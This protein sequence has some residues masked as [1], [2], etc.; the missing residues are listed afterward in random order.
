MDPIT[1]RASALNQTALDWDGNLRRIE[2]AI[3]RAQNDGVDVL[4]LPELCLSGYGC[5]DAFL[6]P[7]TRLLALELLSTIAPQTKDITVTL[8]LPLEIDSTLYN[9]VAVVAEGR[10]HGFALKRALAGDGVYYEP[11]WFRPWRGVTKPRFEFGG[12]QLPVGDLVFERD[13]VLFGIEICEDAWVNPRRAVDIAATGAN[14]ILNPSASHFALQKNIQRMSLIREG[15]DLVDGVYVYSNLLGNDAGRLI[16]DGDTVIAGATVYHGPRFSYHSE[17]SVTAAIELRA[18]NYRPESGYELVSLPTSAVTSVSGAVPQVFTSCNERLSDFEEVYQ[19]VT[20]GLFDYMRKSRSSGFVVSL[21]GGVDS[22]VTAYLSAHAI[23]CAQQE[24]SEAEWNDA[25]GYLA[26]NVPF[27][28][29]RAVEKLLTCVYQGT[30]QSSLQ[31]REAARAIA[32]GLG[33]AFLE[34]EIDPL[35][36]QYKHLITDAGGSA[37]LPTALEWNRHDLALQNIQART[38]GPGVWLVANLKNALLLATSNRSEAAVGYTTMDGDTCGGL[39]PIAGLSKPF[40]REFLQWIVD[41]GPAGVGPFAAAAKV[42]AMEPTAELR[43]A[44]RSQTDETDLMPYDV[45]D[46]I[47]H[48]FLLERLM[49]EQMVETL[50][51]EFSQYAAD[52]I[53]LW[54][55]RFFQLWTR[56]QWKRE[57]YAPSF[58]LDRVSL[59]PKAWCRFPILS[60]G[61]DRELRRGKK[62]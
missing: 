59:D 3:A 22:A 17:A 52:D 48:L 40:L 28:D 50:E 9:A 49:P 18:A 14:A 46:R 36:E 24:L 10:V 7:G 20:L 55:K 1:F 16:F 32:H 44:E 37:G 54:M 47:E 62:L 51:R 53:A 61:F 12:E 38:R 4:C 26:N 29:S 15:A 58:H 31:T 41:T 23:R 56:N 25:V 27:S 5:E 2:T 19:A 21:S 11:R 39:S 45:L 8:G 57:R 6:H 33:S 35:V 43:P 42:T 30:A 13:G 60:G 34:F